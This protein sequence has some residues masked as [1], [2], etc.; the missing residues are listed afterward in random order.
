MT[1]LRIDFPLRFV[2]V[3]RFCPFQ[4]GQSGEQSRRGCSCPP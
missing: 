1:R 4:N 2:R 3:A